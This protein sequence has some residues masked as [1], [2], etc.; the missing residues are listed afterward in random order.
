MAS[1]VAA[2]IAPPQAVELLLGQGPGRLA[3][4]PAGRATAPRRPGGFPT[5]ARTAW[6]MI[7]ALTGTTPRPTRARKPARPSSAASGPTRRGPARGGP[8]PGGACPAARGGRR[9]RTRGRSGPTAPGRPLRRRV[10]S[11]ASASSTTTRPDIPRCIP[12]SGPAPPSVS[13]HIGLAAPAGR[14]SVR[15][16]RTAAISPGACGRQTQV[17][18][19]STATI[20]RPRPRAS[21]RARAR[22]TS[23]SSGIAAGTVAPLVGD[24]TA[25]CTG[26]ALATAAGLN[27][28]VPLLAVGLLARWTSLVDLGGDWSVLAE[29]PV[30]W[31]W[32]RSRPPTSRATRCRPSITC[33]TWPGR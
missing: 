19:S 11:P 1:R 27:A 31:R 32:P 10:G 33:S 24:V 9:R 17:S 16:S 12:R 5:P 25:Y 6:S 8:A 26:L 23:G 21:T 22:S 30:L 18:V 13:N 2:R 15:P 7:R 14:G 4:V 29:T 20:V 3:R 28:W